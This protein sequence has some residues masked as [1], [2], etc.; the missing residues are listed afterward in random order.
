MMSWEAIGSDMM[1]YDAP[2]KAYD[3]LI[4]LHEAQDGHHICACHA[5]GWPGWRVRLGPANRLGG[6]GG[7]LRLPAHA[8]LRQE[9]PGGQGDMGC[10]HVMK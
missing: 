4:W 9:G 10:M 2:M 1:P 5:R 8:V 6:C 3:T 7:L